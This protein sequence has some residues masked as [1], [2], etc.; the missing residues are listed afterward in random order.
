MP[1]MVT[2]LCRCGCGN[3]KEVR[4]SDVKR[5]WGKFFSKSCKAKWQ[6]ENNPRR[7]KSRKKYTTRSQ[8]KAFKGSVTDVEV[9]L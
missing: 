4:F 7:I 1:R 5:G 3:K 8:T 2:I 9:E 6:A